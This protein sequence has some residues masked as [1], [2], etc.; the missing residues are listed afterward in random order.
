[1]IYR[2]LA[3]VG[4]IVIL[5]GV[6]SFF[7]MRPVTTSEDPSLAGCVQAD[8]ELVSLEREQENRTKV[9][10][11]VKTHTPIE[12]PQTDVKLY[13]GELFSSMIPFDA[14]MLEVSVSDL[15]LLRVSL[16][17][18]NS[19]GRTIVTYFEDGPIRKTF[20]GHQCDWILT[21]DNG[22]ITQQDIQSKES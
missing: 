1:M 18:Y 17:Y 19:E 16:D 22:E 13:E 3:V 12:Q 15:G 7:T 4:G 6:I 2:F 20:R 9:F 10:E 8:P 11:L 21:N 14:E 5:A